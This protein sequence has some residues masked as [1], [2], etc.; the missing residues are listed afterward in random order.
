MDMTLVSLGVVFISGTA[1]I[2]I[3]GYFLYQKRKQLHAYQYAAVG[4]MDDPQFYAPEST[5]DQENYFGQFNPNTN[6]PASAQENRYAFTPAQP[7]ET[8]TQVEYNILLGT[9]QERSLQNTAEQTP[10]VEDSFEEDYSFETTNTTQ[11]SIHD[12]SLS[13][14]TEVNSEEM[15]LS[16]YILAE[17]NRPFVGYEL[18][19]ALLSSGL[20]YGDMNIFHRYE[21]IHGRGTP[22]FSLASATEPGTFDLNR[23]GEVSCQ[24]LCLFMDLSGVRDPIMAFEKM[25]DTANQLV[26]DLGGEIRDQNGQIFTIDSLNTY[27][28]QVRRFVVGNHQTQD[29]I[30]S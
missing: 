29:E 26:D 1:L 24:G 2:A 23:M 19:Q 9:K 25:I 18:L 7:Q 15:F 8:Q 5:N 22:L 16:I 30:V 14:E 11:S 21:R 28:E 6:V 27:R 10:V 17:H 4:S 13:Q 12:Q 20:R 3:L